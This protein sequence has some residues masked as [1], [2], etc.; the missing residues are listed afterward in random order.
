MCR[1]YFIKHVIEGKGRR[2]GGGEGNY[3][4]ILRK[5]EVTGT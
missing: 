1:N 2:Y 4:V 5:R 3:C